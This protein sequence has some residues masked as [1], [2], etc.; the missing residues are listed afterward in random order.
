MV[1]AERR[2]RARPQLPGWRWWRCGGNPTVVIDR[3]V[4]DHLEILRAPLRRRICVCLIKSVSHAYAFDWFLLDPVDR[5]RRW[6]AGDFKDG[7]DDV[8]HVM[9]LG[10]N[11]A[12]ILDMAGPRN[13]QTLPGATEMRRHLLRPLERCIKRP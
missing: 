12:H 6:D 4:A 5:I 8:D 11:R 7:R 9:E 13:S 3:A 10:A 2:H 1:V